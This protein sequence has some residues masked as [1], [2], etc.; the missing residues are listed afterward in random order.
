MV[1]WRRG[2]VVTVR[3][4]SV[5]IPAVIVNVDQVCVPF[6]AASVPTPGVVIGADPY[7]G[8]ISESWVAPGI[9][10]VDDMRVVDGDV[11]IFFLHGF[12]DDGLFLD[13]FHL[14]IALQ[15]SVV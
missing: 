1:P 12:D 7:S 2:V 9:G 10:I 5:V 8:T 14:F 6:E 15:M 3:S 13:D 4:R 11:Y